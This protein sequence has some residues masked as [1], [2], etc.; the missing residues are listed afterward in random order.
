MVAAKN[1]WGPLWPLGEV[2]DVTE[3]G[4]LKTVISVTFAVVLMKTHAL[5]SMDD[6]WTHRLNSGIGRNILSILRV[7]CLCLT[8]HPRQASHVRNH[9]CFCRCIIWFEFGLSDRPVF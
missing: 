8:I 9:H 3:T 7:I 4:K 2:S 6:N 1:K 5:R